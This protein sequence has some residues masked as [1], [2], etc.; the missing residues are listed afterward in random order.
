MGVDPTA[1]LA[2][3]GSGRPLP[4][5]TADIGTLR[6][7]KNRAVLTPLR[8][9]YGSVR[10]DQRSSGRHV[11][12]QNP[13]VQFNF[14]RLTILMKAV[15]A[16]LQLRNCKSARSGLHE[17]DRGSRHMTSW[18]SKKLCPSSFIRCR[19]GKAGHNRL[20]GWNATR[21]FGHEAIWPTTVPSNRER[22]WRS[23]CSAPPRSS[24]AGDAFAR[25]THCAGT[26]LALIALRRDLRH[27]ARLAFELWPDFD[28][29]Q[30]RT[31]LR[32]LLH[33][34]RQALPD[35]GEFF[36]IDNE[37]IALHSSE[38]VDVDVWSFQD[39]IDGGD[40]ERAAD[41]TQVICCR[42]L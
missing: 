7:G 41:P 3:A 23:S 5:P 39:A 40:N 29:S 20:N 22:G 12:S 1:T 13:D 18:F 10:L 37:T 30:A 11:F 8:H 19:H 21:E 6:A 28:E 9:A 26:F 34:L 17:A 24:W 32:K 35:I 33:E 27:R 16:V 15:E 38:A 4:D 2:G 14:F 36:E 42:L 25:S 31:N